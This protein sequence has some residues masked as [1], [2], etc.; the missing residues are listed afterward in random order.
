MLATAARDSTA[1]IFDLR[2]M[3]DVLLLKGHEKDIM[4]MCWHP[5]HHSLL[6]TA[7]YDGC[8]HHYLLDESNL[9]EGSTP[10]RSPYDSPDPTNAPIQ[11]I[12]PAHRVPYAH[13]GPIWS[14]D[15]HPLGHILCSGS[16]DRVTR[17]W[18]RARPGET[19]CFNDRYHL[20]DSAAKAHGAWS[21]TKSRHYQRDEEEQDDDDNEALVDQK[22]PSRQTI[23]PGLP[24]LAAALKDGSSTGGA[25][26]PLFPG[27][28]STPPVAVP[29][30]TLPGMPPQLPPGMDPAI[31]GDPVA[32]Q[33]FLA[34]AGRGAPPFPPPGQGLPV[35]PPGFGFPHNGMPPSLPGFVPPIVESAGAG[36]RRR[37][38]LPSQEESLRSE[39]SRGNYK[40]VR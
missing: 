2:M 6:T 17:F 36:G 37:A 32:L 33:K 8:M 14:L 13:E 19:G 34:G 12:Y 22:M 40:S 39:Q 25:Q 11:T 30:P 23:V 5:I 9:P 38:P 18:S 31:L 28:T 27:M 1:R 20:G 21:S 15:W 16:N 29:P 3:R 26:Q 35:P 7:S 24:G 4:S 10:T